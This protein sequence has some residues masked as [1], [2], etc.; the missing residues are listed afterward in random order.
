MATICAG[1]VRIPARRCAELRAAAPSG[2]TPVGG[3]I[4]RGSPTAG[5][6]GTGVRG[7]RCVP[8]PPTI[9]GDCS[10]SP[11]KPGDSPPPWRAAY[12]AG[13]KR[14]DHC[15]LWRRPVKRF[16]CAELHPG[17][18]RVFT[19]PTDQAVLDQVLAHAAAD[20]GLP[21]PSMTFIERVVI[22]THPLTPGARATAPTGPGRR[23][24]PGSVR[25]AHRCR[26]SG[27][28]AAPPGRTGRARCRGPGG[29]G[30]RADRPA[31]PGAPHVP[32]RMLAVPRGRRVRGHDGAVHPRRPGPGPT[33]DGRGA[34]AAA[35]RP[36]RRP[37]RRRREGGVG[38]H[39]R[40]RRQPGPDHPRLAGIHRQVPR[41]PAP[42]PRHR[43][44]HLGRTRRTPSSSKPS[45]TRRC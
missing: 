35:A 21:R 41:R 38:G 39:G 6:C 17:C 37:R 13:A 11:Q 27:R 4:T 5:A 1:P 20:H 23:R 30:H 12:R 43:A 16:V 40:P 3:S 42:G 26:P 15:I 44:T 14:D 19:G 31:R 28:S 7:W 22:A 25:R 9:G 24:S 10:L 36:A 29:D 34:P 2:L 8:A 18:D 32:A 45:S 33:G